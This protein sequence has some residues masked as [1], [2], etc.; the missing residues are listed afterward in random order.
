MSTH[1]GRRLT[2]ARD[3]RPAAPVR[4]AH[5]GL[6]NFFRA[7]Q[8]A[9]TD[10]A[11][12]AA[13]WG[14]A[15]FTGRSAAG[16]AD[17]AAQD[18]LY[19]LVVRDANGDRPRTVSALS[20]VHGSAVLDDWRRTFALPDLAVV[21]TTVTEA[22]YRRD[23][24]GRLA[25]DD[26]EVG[27]DVAALQAHGPRADART[28]P[29]K[30]LAGV[31][32]RA[33]AGLRPLSLVP[34]DNV[35][36][37]G[38]MLR[39]VLLELAAAAGHDP[40]VVDAGVRF[41]TTMVDRITPRTTDADRAGLL[42]AT[43]VDDPACVVTEPY[44]EWV[45]GGTFAAGRPAWHE[46]GARFVEDVEP[47]ERRKLLLLNGSHSLMAYA[48]SLRGHTT[49]AEAIRDDTVRAWV[50][51]WWDD[52]C[53]CLP[54]PLAD[55]ATYRRA[56]VERYE[57]P[58][59]RH[60]L[61]QIAA[62][63]TQ[64]VP[65]RVVPVLRAGLAEGRVPLGATRVIAAWTLHLRGQGAA[66]TDPGAAD[67]REAVAAVPVRDA[68]AMVLDALGVDDPTALDAVGDQAAAMAGGAAGPAG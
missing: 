58:R 12:D 22:G 18:G 3:G 39:Q 50:E 7:H 38:P 62:D 44:A 28:A 20:A 29:G 27:A 52:A 49:V 32:V 51:E 47:W 33:D 26:P 42:A 24:A 56:L 41:V 40:S 31:L 36:G 43:G 66:V 17:L 34:C 14:I 48:A 67:L 6:G 2:R 61:A 60:L 65:I 13:A 64:K 9:Y 54:L 45:L 30:V 55:L 11:P 35:P 4:I 5:L 8:A 68:A 37:N 19:T 23:A 25:A 15:A 63:G 10:E 1:A 57:N 21:T 46:A 53:R 59:I 16:A